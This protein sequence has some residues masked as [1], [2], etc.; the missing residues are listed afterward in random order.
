MESKWEQQF[1]NLR[2]LVTDLLNNPQPTTTQQVART[3]ELVQ[4][5]NV[6][7]AITVPTT[8]LTTPSTSTTT[9]LISNDGINPSLPHSDMNITKTT[10]EFELKQILWA[11][12][13]Q[14]S[15]VTKQ[16]SFK[17]ELYENPVIFLNKLEEYGK[18][19][20]IPDDCLLKLSLECLT[21]SA[22]TW[23]AIYRNDWKIYID[24]KRDFLNTFW[25]KEKQR[26]IKHKI[27]NDRYNTNNGKSM[28]A[29]FSKYVNLASFLEPKLSDEELLNSLVRHYPT[30]I[31]I[32]W[33]AREGKSL[34]SFANYLL[35]GDSVVQN[36]GLYNKSSNKPSTA[37]NKH[38]EHKQRSFTRRS[39]RA[40]NKPYNKN[41]SSATNTKSNITP[42]NKQEKHTTQKQN[43]QQGN[44]KKTK[45]RANFV[46]KK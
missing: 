22:K 11:L 16:P 40:E 32:N 21:G 42:F 18:S 10:S 8:T 19:W 44:E 17:G 41:S 2:D 13:K 25:T 29:H 28:L 38:Q 12:T 31:Q 4:S 6:T 7:D 27:E 26:E 24:F 34:K 3:E 23:T 35:Q 43:K 39:T 5:V 20:S 15:M 36:V 9:T 33:L 14:N 30:N 37:F 1:Q 46:Q 45:T